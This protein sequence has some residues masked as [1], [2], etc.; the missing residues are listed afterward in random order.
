MKTNAQTLKDRPLFA[1]ISGGKDSTAMGL[2]LREQGLNFTPVFLDTGWEHPETYLY[3]EEV[4]EPLFGKFKIIKNDRYFK[5][6][7]GWEGG[8]EQIILENKMFPSGFAKFCTKLLKVVPI[9]NFYA[10][11]R[12]SKG[13]K[14]VNIVGIRAEESLRRAKM[15]EIEEQ[16]EATVWR[17]LLNWTE[18][19]VIEIHKAHNVPPN[20]LYLR[21][22]ARV[23]CYPCI[24]ARKQEIRH[25][26]LVDPERI[27][28]IK[29]LEDRVNK[30]RPQGSKQASFFKSRRADKQPMGILDIV[31][32][33]RSDKKLSGTLDD[34]E[35]I[36]D[37]GCMRWGLC[38]HPK[39][40]SSAR[41]AR[42]PKQHRLF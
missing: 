19:Q 5:E 11:Y 13:I 1:S 39:S 12:A 10:E 18:A 4:L 35:E 38:E 27:N 15:K 40:Q 30:I 25:L 37:N 41:R 22:A 42:G 34:L 7:E 2:W 36:E 8:M 9:Q 32:W 29:D 6:I 23:G 20:P 24:Y 26:A 21:G 31:K 16:D 28:K 33:A 17:P 3:I 14:P